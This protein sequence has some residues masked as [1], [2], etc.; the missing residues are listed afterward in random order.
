[1]HKRKRT[2]TPPLTPEQ[3]ATPATSLT[4]A[5]PLAAA[6]NQIPTR[7]TT[8]TDINTV[9][10]HPGY[11]DAVGRV[12]DV[13]D[14][15]R[16][17]VEGYPSSFPSEIQHKTLVRLTLGLD[18]SLS[19][20]TG[21]GKTLIA[22]HA[23]WLVGGMCTLVSCPLNTLIAQ[24]IKTFAAFMPHDRLITLTS[25]NA[26]DIVT[27]INA[28]PLGGDPLIIFGHPEKLVD[29]LFPRLTSFGFQRVSLLVVDEAHCIT[30]WGHD[31]RPKFRELI[32]FTVA[33]GSKMRVLTCSGTTTPVTRELICRD[34]NLPSSTILTGTL[35]RPDMRIDVMESTTELRARIPEDDNV[36]G[37]FSNRFKE[38]IFTVLED[39]PDK[40]VIIFCQSKK[41]CK[42]FSKALN[43]FLHGKGSDATSSSFYRSTSYKMA[44][45]L[46][47]FQNVDHSC[48]ILCC[49]VALGMGFHVGNIIAA[50]F[51]RLGS[52]WAETM[53][54]YSRAHRIA[55]DYTSYG[56]AILA[57]SLDDYR[58][59]IKHSY[60]LQATWQTEE[61]QEVGRRLQRSTNS[62]F[63]LLLNPDECLHYLIEI[64]LDGEGAPQRCT[65]KSQAPCCNCRRR[66]VA[67][68][69]KSSAL[70]ALAA[71]SKDSV[72]GR[73]EALKMLASTVSISL[74]DTKRVQKVLIWKR[75]ITFQQNNSESISFDVLAENSVVTE[76]L[77]E[78]I[79]NT[80]RT[81]RYGIQLALLASTVAKETGQYGLNVAHTRWCLFWFM[82]HGLLEEVPDAS[83]VS[84]GFI[85]TT[86]PKDH[87][88]LTAVGQTT[89]AQDWP[90]VPINEKLG[91]YT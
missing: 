76:L 57:V 51:L 38:K 20:C 82:V 46:N 87:V 21:G 58:R 63:K 52:N 85:R 88:I 55:N 67:Q 70:A 10:D 12:N 18:V 4:E 59:Q 30:D 47:E 33:K 61:K 42:S 44:A 29:K 2:T 69:T 66:W 84:P 48:R 37:H 40:N 17:R 49:T 73:K 6:T 81:K 35:N 34:L 39:N 71:V 45:L 13:V 32:K 5:P 24:H 60:E 53:Q 68:S 14:Y 78:S 26:A 41:L 65:P 86:A 19:L 8:S 1:M 11:E 75:T 64:E 50:F 54:F 62:Q 3:P 91:S 79:L 28:L 31:F 9:L 43:S 56:L 16:T 22:V 15:F 7:C 89:P 23:P 77:G 90:T 25:T 80:L 72:G 36:T 83:P 74:E 27:K